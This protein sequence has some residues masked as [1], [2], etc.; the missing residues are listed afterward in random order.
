MG[1]ECFYFV[2][3]CQE[4]ADQAMRSI[5]QFISTFPAFLLLVNDNEDLRFLT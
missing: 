5:N 3:T 2:G 1:N 4:M